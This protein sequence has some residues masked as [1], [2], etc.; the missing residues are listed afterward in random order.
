MQAKP[1][2]ETLGKSPRHRT[3]ASGS[4]LKV[5]TRLSVDPSCADLRA[6]PTERKLTV[7]ASRTAQGDCS[8]SEA[9]S[10]PTNISERGGSKTPEFASDG[11]HRQNSLVGG[12]PRRPALSV[13]S[14]DLRSRLLSIQGVMP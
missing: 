5:P 6:K 12:L 3:D 7:W 10:A 14:R 8:Y 9:S 2:L 4:A 13:F 11:L 1:T